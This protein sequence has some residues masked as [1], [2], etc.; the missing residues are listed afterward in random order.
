[1]PAAATALVAAVADGPPA[2]VR[3]ARVTVAVR[4]HV[5]C[6]GV[7]AVTVAIGSRASILP[8]VQVQVGERTRRTRPLAAGR[9]ALVRMRID[10]RGR[11]FAVRATTAGVRPTVRV[12]VA[13]VSASPTIANPAVGVPGTLAASGR[14]PVVV[15]TSNSAVLSAP[16]TAGTDAAPGSAGSLGATGT[17]GTTGSTASTGST[18]AHGSTGSTGSTGA[19]GPT[20]STGSTG[21]TGAHGST[22]SSSSDGAPALVLPPGFAAVASYGTLAKDFEFTGS[23]L[24]DGWTAGNG[25]NWGA[26]ATEWMSSQVSLTGSAVA[27]TAIPHTSPD[28]SPYES[29]WISTSGGYDFHYG[30]VDYRAKMPAGQGLWSG[31]WMINPGYP[32]TGELDIAEELLGNLRT[33]YGSA[34]AWDGNTAL[35]GETQQGQLTSDATGWHD[36]QLVWQ[37]GML[38][39]AI[40]GVAYAQYTQAQATAAGD[41]WPFDSDSMYLIATLT[42]AGASEWGG[43]P[44]ASTLF[45]ASM[46]IQSVKVWQ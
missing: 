7:F 46:Q 45:P 24:P 16:T 31:A 35:W 40:D 34:H 3:P 30:M 28:G 14:S 12:S 23:T 26:Q 25:F 22:G 9:R 10:V 29:G 21:S 44:T 1:M 11:W 5:R 18:G 8:S 42:V 33:V 4:E 36:Y 6:A 41:S 2:P 37:P 17:H 32:T 15:A 20:G 39:W 27:L 43:P 13:L 19:H 38:T